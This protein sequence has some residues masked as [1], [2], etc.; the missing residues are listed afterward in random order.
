M[1]RVADDPFVDEPDDFGVVVVGH[2]LRADLDQFLVLVRGL[3][4]LLC[5]LELTPMRERL[6]AVYIFSRLQCLS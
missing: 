5:Q 3:L 2:V 1:D 4:H 6:F